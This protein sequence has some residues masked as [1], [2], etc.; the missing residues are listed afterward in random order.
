MQECIE[1]LNYPVHFY[2]HQVPCI[3]IL[4]C[5]LSARISAHWLGVH[6]SESGIQKLEVWAGTSA[7][8]EDVISSRTVHGI[9]SVTFVL[10]NDLT[11]GTKVY[12]TLRVWNNAGKCNTF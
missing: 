12:V 7:G 2:G 5:C 8:A 4:E 9:S 6:D 11:Q 10:D 3:F 1:I